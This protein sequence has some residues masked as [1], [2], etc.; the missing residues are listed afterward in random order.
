MTPAPAAVVVLAAGQGTRMRS[1]TPKVLH[2]IGG[3]SLVG[4]AVAAARGLE[5]EQLLVVVGHGREEVAAHL[6]EVEPQ[7]RPVVQEE[8]NGTGHAVRV[9]LLEAAPDVAGTVLVVCGDVP[10][11]RTET[12]TALL[13]RHHDATN[14]ATV[15]TAVVPD[16]GGYGRV[17]RDGAGE[18]L[19]IVEHRD[20]T[21]EQRAIAEINSG[22][23]AFDGKLLREALAR[24]SA[25]NSAGEEYLTDVVGIL[26]SDGRRVGALAAGDHHEILGVNDRVQLAALGRLLNQRVC[27]AWMR[28]G[29]TIVDPA[30]TWI[31]VGV[32]FEPDVLVHPGTQL[33]GTTS[34]AAGA[35]IGPDST[36]RDTPVGAG[37]EVVATRAVGAEIGPGATV[38]PYTYLRPG[39]RLGAGAKAGGFVEIK[40]STIGDGSKVP[41][42]SYV[43]DADI[44]AGSNISAA[45]V[46]VN[47]DGQ[48][49]SRT[50][51]G[52]HAFVG[53]DTMLV[54]PVRVSDGAYVAAGSVIT[55]DVPPGALAVARGQQRN[56]EG[57]VERKR[58]GSKAALAAAAAA[59]AQR[60]PEE[61]PPD[62]EAGPTESESGATG[63]EVPATG[64]NGG[65][66]E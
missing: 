23:Y 18:V 57:W 51:V 4:H 21:P 12:L 25:G 42:L 13:E 44:G 56:I 38:G 39:T 1:A 16:P 37:A 24:L 26:R 17:V 54:A 20:A 19:G 2:E 3:R 50:V 64:D 60:R 61:G 27:E 66:G 31:D 32:T 29:V 52:D 7:A 53:C 59:A 28:A 34:V 33:H 10:L 55:K 30:T 63:D 48:T 45:V 62:G 43:G 11:L 40:N 47:Y 35:V 46:V 36:L 49:K 5:P 41:H 65:N 15:L 9:A 8:Q 22:V 58:P 6:A 14:A